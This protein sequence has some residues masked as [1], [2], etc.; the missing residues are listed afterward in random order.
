M[1]DCH[2]IRR[3]CSLFLMVGGIAVLPLLAK[4][5]SLFCV[6]IDK[7]LKVHQLDSL[8]MLRSA[9]VSNLVSL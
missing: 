4:L 2:T 8:Q 6:S 7:T 9:S 1:S 5:F 3:L